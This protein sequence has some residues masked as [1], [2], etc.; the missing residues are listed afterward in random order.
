M[1]RAQLDE[2]EYFPSETV[3][4]TVKQN[5]EIIVAERQTSEEEMRRIPEIP[6]PQ[7]VPE[8]DDDWL[9]MLDVVPRET[10]YVPPGIA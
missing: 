8:R 1:D 9:L 6:P 5:T 10:L 2:G 3:V 4:T 7:T